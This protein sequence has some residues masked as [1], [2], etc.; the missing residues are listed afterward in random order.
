MVLREFANGAGSVLSSEIPFTGISVL[1][2]LGVGAAIFGI[3]W[4]TKKGLQN[5]GILGRGR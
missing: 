5:L 4:L 3:A 1:Q 2:G